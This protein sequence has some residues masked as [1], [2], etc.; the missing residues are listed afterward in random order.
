[1]QSELEPTIQALT[2]AFGGQ[3]SEFRGDVQL[4]LPADKIVP[5]CRMLNDEL[6]FTLLSTM[7]AVDFWPT[8]SPD[9][10]TGTGSPD[11]LTGKENPRFHVL[12]QFT[13]VTHN[14]SLG[15]LV[16]VSGIQ[17]ALPTV[18]G[19]FANA[20]W[21]EREIWDLFGIQFEGHPDL[22]RIMMPADWEGH[23]LRKDYPLGYEEPQFSFNTKEIDQRKPY[24][25][26]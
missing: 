17:P 26:E 11:G 14:L 15:L 9:G 6:G 20:V 5:A 4:T 8:G 16:P 24:A 2:A 13:S 22:R 10:L 21:R 3:V 18:T 25:K 23:P 1:M 12:Y 7:T 19:V